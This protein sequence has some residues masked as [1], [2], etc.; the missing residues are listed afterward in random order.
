MLFKV[1][2]LLFCC[3]WSFDI[4]CFIRNSID[5]TTLTYGVPDYRDFLTLSSLTLTIILLSNTA[6]TTHSALKERRGEFVS[7][8]HP[9]LG[10]YFIFL[11]FN[12]SVLFL[13]NNSMF[14]LSLKDSTRFSKSFV[15]TSKCLQVGS[16]NFLKLCNFNFLAVAEK[17]IIKM[18]FLRKANQLLNWI[19]VPVLSGAQ[20]RK[21]LSPCFISTLNLDYTVYQAYIWLY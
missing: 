15:E 4:E 16:R 2:F 3:Y 10:F 5:Q 18:S 17:S 9:R 14:E 19:I 21:H 6:K 7:K 20:Y 12:L 11:H 8:I 1:Y 13:T